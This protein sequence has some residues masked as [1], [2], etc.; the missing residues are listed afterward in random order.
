MQSSTLAAASR[1][2]PGFGGRSRPTAI[3]RLTYFDLAAALAQLGRSD[4]AHSAAKAG[5]ALNTAFTIARVRAAWTPVSDHPTFLA[6]LEQIFEG[7]RK[8]GLPEQ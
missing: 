8:A 2:S 5:L 3:F 1:R 7:M 6:Q 4:E